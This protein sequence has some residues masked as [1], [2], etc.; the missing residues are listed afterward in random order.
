MTVASPPVR[1]GT[2]F[3]IILVKPGAIAS[4]FFMSVN[5]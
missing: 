5:P 3:F 1:V 2:H 4:G